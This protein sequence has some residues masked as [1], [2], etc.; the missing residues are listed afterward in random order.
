MS[1]NKTYKNGQLITINNHIFRVVEKKSTL[2]T[3]VFCKEINTSMNLPCRVAA[4]APQLFSFNCVM[5]KPTQT[6]KFIK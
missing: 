2:A 6:L 3:C 5:L 4:K 1:L